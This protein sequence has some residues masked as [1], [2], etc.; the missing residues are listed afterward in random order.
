MADKTGKVRTIRMYEAPDPVEE[1]KKLAA[2]E[3]AKAKAEAKA[4]KDAE[5]KREA[6]QTLTVADF[7]QL[8]KEDYATLS[9]KPRRRAR[10]AALIMLYQVEQGECP[11]HIAERVLDDVNVTGENAAFA[12]DLARAAFDDK[13]KSDQLL[14]AYSREWSVDRF[15]PVDRVILHLAVSELQHDDG[16]N[17]AVIINE[18]IEMGKK[19]GDKESGP[20]INGILDNIKKQ[21]GKGEEK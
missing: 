21:I 13:E 3:K 1:A 5:A 17:T 4:A 9:D 6:G 11:W 8:N 2:Y 20:F 16:S 15:A 18:A 10:E 14:S 7:L 19:F 12:A